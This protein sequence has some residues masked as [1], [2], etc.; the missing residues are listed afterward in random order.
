[1]KSKNIF[2]AVTFLFIFSAGIFALSSFSSGDVK[3]QDQQNVLMSTMQ[4][5]S[6][7]MNLKCGDGN[8]TDMKKAKD[9]AKTVKKEMKC[10]DGKCGDGKCGGDKKAK[11][12][13]GKCGDDKKAAKKA[14]KAKKEMKCGAGKC[15]GA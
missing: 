13:D 10:G 7:A 1:M 6:T 11:C 14:E 8:G 12:G 4:H 15:G 5:S 9:S 3:K 2:K